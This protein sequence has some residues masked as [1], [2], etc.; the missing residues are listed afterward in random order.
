MPCPEL[1][2]QPKRGDLPWGSYSKT[3]SGEKSSCPQAGSV[4]CSWIAANSLVPDETSSPGLLWS[5]SAGQVQAAQSCR[6]TCFP[7]PLHSN[8]EFSLPTMFKYTNHLMLHPWDT[9]GT[10]C[11]SVCQSH[12]LRNHHLPPQKPHLGLFLQSL[13]CCQQILHIAA[14][15]PELQRERLSLQSPICRGWF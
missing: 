8:T 1:V 2:P 11:S 10:S 13:P 14:V 4:S 7:D 15:S 3:H 5:S 12:S 6:V 9:A